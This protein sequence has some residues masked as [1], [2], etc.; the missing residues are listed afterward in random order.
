MIE[1][2]APKNKTNSCSAVDRKKTGM[3][4][5]NIWDK[6]IEY[7]RAKE[8]H[9]VGDLTVKFFADKFELNY[10][11]LS[12]AFKC[13]QGF[14]LNEFL[15]KEKMIKCAVFLRENEDVT[16]NEM[17]EI[18][19]FSEPRYFIKVFKRYMGISPGRYQKS[20]IGKKFTHCGTP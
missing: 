3:A 10:T 18:I 7:I 1:E 17:A 4:N 11:Y 15:Q 5:S 16:I 6:I 9:E 14:S 13:R 8:I 2:T 12:R 20:R 19:G